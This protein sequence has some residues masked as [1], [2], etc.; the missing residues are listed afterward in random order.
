M[1]RQA[2]INE[3]LAT[4]PWTLGDSERGEVCK[5]IVTLLEENDAEWEEAIDARVDEIE[6]DR[7]HE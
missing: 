1:E 2:R 3:L 6:R 4:L 5:I 7:G